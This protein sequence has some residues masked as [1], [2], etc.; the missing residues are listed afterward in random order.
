MGTAPSTLGTTP[1]TLG[2]T[3][4]T[5]HPPRAVRCCGSPYGTRGAGG[6]QEPWGCWGWRAGA[7]C[8]VPLGGQAA[9]HP[10]GATGAVPGVDPGQFGRFEEGGVRAPHLVGVVCVHCQQVAVA[11]GLGMGLGGGA[12]PWGWGWGVGLG[13]IGR[14]SGQTDELT[15]RRAPNPVPDPTG[16]GF[17]GSD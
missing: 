4:S 14:I 3:P 5:H 16:G 8:G 9:G 11:D 1:S 13:K 12:R 6:Q 17:H 10:H 2:G 7:T 15:I